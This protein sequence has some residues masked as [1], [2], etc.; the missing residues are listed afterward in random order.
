MKQQTAV[1][2]GATGLIGRHVVE[3]L[4]ADDTFN[5]VRL[6]VRKPFPMHHPKL[7]VQQV[8]F[9]NTNE[10]KTGLGAGDCLFCCVGTTNS[11]VKGDKTAYR[12]VDYDI[13]VN[14]ARFAS[15][16]GFSKFLLVSAIGSNTSSR[17]FYVKL[18]GEVEQAVEKYTFRSIH[19]FQPSIL[20]GKRNEVRLG[21]SIGKG[22]MKALSFLFVGSLKKYKGIEAIDVAKAMVEA[23]KKGDSGLKKYT[24]TEMMELI[25]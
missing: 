4:L 14:A 18:K 16:A 8:D 15:E 20:L 13:P 9:N 11:K 23:A 21:E 10:F 22:V 19:I 24:Y 12:K 5:K 1:V 17:N 25:Q 2:L 7:E 3:L 6:L